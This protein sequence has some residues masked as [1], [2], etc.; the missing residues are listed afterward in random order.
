MLATI[1]LVVGELRLVAGE[2]DTTTVE[3]RPT[4]PS[5]Q[6]DVQAAEK[7][8]VECSADRLQVTAPRTRNWISR[9]SGGSIDVVIE[10]PAGSSVRATGAMADFTCEG[11]LGDCWVKNGIGQVRIEQAE[12]LSVKS[13]AGDIE[14]GRVAGVAELATGSGDVRA[15]E[16]AGS[17][18]VKNSNGD[19]WV[20]VAGSSLRLNAANGNLAVA[21]A[22]ADVVAKAANGDVRLG[23]SSRERSFSRPRWG[24]SRSASRPARRRGWMSTPR[25][26]GSTTCSRPARHPRSPP[27]ASRS[28]PARRSATS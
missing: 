21:L 17:A 11:P 27:T 2:R 24:T 19:T 26:G 20:G 1:G 15:G 23:R 13:G 12:K 6:E 7:T 3:V 8:R 9:S 25:P 5:N 10:L 4:D 14:I 18:V 16:L 22:H 28:V